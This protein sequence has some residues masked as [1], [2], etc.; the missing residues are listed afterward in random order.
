VLF[1]LGATHSFVSNECMGRLELAMRELECELIVATPASGEVST[2]S[3]CVGCPMEVAGCRFTLNLI[4]LPMEGLD[5]IVGMDWLSSNLV[6]ID[7]GWHRIVFPDTVGLEL[8]SSNQAVSEIEARATCYMIVAQAEKMSTTKK[9]SRIPIVEEYTDVFPDEISELPPMRDV[10][11]SIDRILG[12]GPVS[13][14]P[15]RMAPAELPE[16]KKQIEDL[17]EKKFIRPSA[18][19]WGAPVLLVKK[20]DGSSRLCVDYRQLNK[21]TIKNKY[22]LPRIDYLLDQLR[23]AAV[24]SKIDLRSGYHQILVRPEDV[25]KTAFRSRYGHYEYVVMPFGVTNAPAIFMDYMNRIFQPYLDQ[26]VV[27]FIDDILIYSERREEHA[28]HLRVVLGI[29]REHQLYGKLSKCEFWLEEVKFLGHVISA[30]GIAVDPTKIET[31]VKWERPQTVSEVRSFL[32]LA[33]YYRRFVEGF[34]K[35]V[36]PLTQLTR[37]DQPF[38]WTDEC[39]A[40]FEDMKRRLTIAPILAIPDTSKIFEVYCDASYQGLGCVLM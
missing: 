32:G 21:L 18:S 23:G 20:K 9:I 10:D 16:L 38:S 1:D 36:S 3:V 37:K 34:S 25:H 12:A 31:V 4:C 7:C 30:Q 19:P 13:M 5:V 22:L 40:C 11:F 17:L 39:E 6:V 8:I 24:F 27:V 15:Y 2:T 33:G 14:A 26:F 29:F 35:M 28:E